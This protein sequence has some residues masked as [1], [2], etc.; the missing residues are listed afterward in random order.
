MFQFAY[1]G[2]AS[3]SA[4]QPVNLPDLS[5]SDSKVLA[6]AAASC[7]LNTDGTCTNTPST[8]PTNWYTPTTGSIGTGYWVRATATSGSLSSG[9]TG[10]WL[11]L[12]SARTWVR[13]NAGTEGTLSATLTLE[14]ATDS[15]GVNIVATRTGIVLSATYSS[16]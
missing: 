10:S 11:Q 12:N 2:I 8:S 4:V 7:T 5:T 14:I 15:G 6:T 16:S 9:T 13:D 1:V 3:G